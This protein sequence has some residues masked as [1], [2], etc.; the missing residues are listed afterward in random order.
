MDAIALNRLAY[1]QF[2]DGDEV[3]DDILVGFTEHLTG[4]CAVDLSCHGGVRVVQRILG[5]LEKR[6]VRLAPSAASLNA[7]WPT[8]NRVE[9]EAIEAV[10][11]AMTRR[12]VWF[13]A[14]MRAQLVRRIE[15]LADLA[16]FDLTAAKKQLQFLAGSEPAARILLEG[17]TIALIGPPNSG[18][19][20][21]FNR[22]VGRDAAMTSPKPGT[23]RDWVSATVEMD[24]VPLTLMDTAGRREPADQLE[25]AAIAK[26]VIEVDRANCVALVLDGSEPLEGMNP[27]VFGMACDLIVVNKADC[28]A[29]WRREE[30]RFLQPSL[31]EKVVR[32]SALSGIGIDRL[33]TVFLE[34]LGLG[35]FDDNVP[36]VF[37]SRQLRSVEAA[38]AAKTA[39]EFTI[40]LRSD[41]IGA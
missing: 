16:M 37:T 33:E 13:A 22:L 5:A 29:N 41:F 4:D 23:T 21:L 25:E 30:L 7:A 17:A 27:L 38:V 6:G 36:S 9:R 15:E 14:R 10:A 1:G 35:S 20:T 32:V 19:S 8:G 2:M 18:K 12:A 28:P 39:V 31:T 34:C 26:G 24:G 3:I 11:T 40:I